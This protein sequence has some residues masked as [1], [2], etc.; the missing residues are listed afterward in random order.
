MERPH[1]WTDLRISIGMFGFYAEW[2]VLFEFR[3]A[4]WHMYLKVYATKPGTIP[5]HVEAG[6]IDAV[7]T[8]EDDCILEDL[9]ETILSEPILQR[10]NPRKRY[11]VK[12]DWCRDGMAAALCQRD[13]SPEAA[14]AEEREAKGGPCE[15]DQTLSGLRLHPVKFISRRTTKEEHSF[16]GYYGEA[17][18]FVWAVER[19]RFYLFGAEFTDIGDMSAMQWFFDRDDLPTHQA[20]RWRQ[21]LLRFW[22]TCTPR[23]ARMVKEVDALS[24][25]NNWMQ[26]WRQDDAQATRDSASL[27]SEDDTLSSMFAIPVEGDDAMSALGFSNVPIMICGP[28][29]APVSEMAAAAKVARTIWNVNA[30]ASV[31]PSTLGYLGIHAE[32]TVQIETDFEWTRR[33]VQQDFVSLSEMIKRTK[34]AR[35]PEFVDWIVITE[36]RDV[37]FDTREQLEDLILLAANK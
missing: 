17:S 30:G 9:K 22:F 16:H 36:P 3:I 29:E 10:P 8:Q 37:S 15:F 25:Y 1:S 21:Q 27:V 11:Y 28:A 7:W 14:A 20:Q 35:S 4:P 5:R 24:R 26:Q 32:I 34:V 33:S 12:H 31:L 13:D 2:I 18:A 19:W 6:Q 23:P